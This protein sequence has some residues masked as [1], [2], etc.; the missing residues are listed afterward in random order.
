MT[1]PVPVVIGVGDVVNR[2]LKLED[3]IEPSEL[4][5]Q[6]IQ[7]ALADAGLSKTDQ[8]KLQASINSI[9]VVRTWTWP[10]PDL[11]G[12]LCSRLGIS[13]T[14]KEYTDH[15]GN[16]PGRIF[17]EAARRIAQNKC[18][19]ALVTGGEALASCKSSGAWG[20]LLLTQ[21]SEC[22]RQ[23]QAIAASGM[24]KTRNSRR[25]SLLSNWSR[26]P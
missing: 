26:P 19:V 16:Q 4:I 21:S 24:D 5:L 6:A 11:P 10:Y 14:H 8:T 2:S 9:A 17:D 13:P 1:Q 7:E 23:S 3:A 25:L 20:S 22:L 15:G 18:K 12:L